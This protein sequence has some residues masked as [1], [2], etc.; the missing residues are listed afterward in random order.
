MKCQIIPGK[1]DKSALTE[2]QPLCGRMYASMPQCSPECRVLRK[3]WYKGLSEGIERAADGSRYS[4]ST[5]TEEGR[6]TRESLQ[7]CFT[8]TI[9]V[10]EL[11]DQR[12]G[13]LSSRRRI[14]LRQPADP[15]HHGRVGRPA[16]GTRRRRGRRVASRG[17]Q[18]PRQGPLVHSCL[19]SRDGR[20]PRL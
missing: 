9:G 4:T 14:T 11:I 10:P 12:C 1:S 5:R 15:A 20:C 8:G 18:P 3:G 17:D 7:M 19:C 2:R 16:G 13:N 6:G